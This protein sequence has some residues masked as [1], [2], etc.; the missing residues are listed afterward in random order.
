VTQPTGNQPAGESPRKC[1]AEIPTR[2]IRAR[3]DAAQSGTDNATHWAAADSYDA[4]SANSPAVR[5]TL[6][7]RSRYERENNGY[8]KGT[9]RTH[10]NYTIHGGPTLRMQTGSDGFNAMVEA[11][12]RRWTKACKFRRKLRVMHMAKVGDGESLAWTFFNPGLADAVQLDF[13]PLECDQCSTPYLPA[14]E[15]SRIDGVHFDRYGNVTA[16]DI[17]PEHPGGQW[18]GYNRDP[19]E[20]PARF[21]LHWFMLER[22]GQ[23]RGIPDTTATLSL[24]AAARRFREATVGA[25]ESAADFGVIF[26][27]NMQVNDGPDE[28]RPLTEI[29][30]DKRMAI[31]APMGWDGHQMKGEHPSTTFDMF[32]K[33]TVN[34][35]AR[36]LSMPRNL[37]MCD[38]SDYNFSSGQL[39]HHTYFAAC[40]NER[41]DGDDLV[42]DPLFGLW[43][44]E[45]RDVYGWAVDPYPI[46]P[47]AWDWPGYPKI[48]P[49]KTAKARAASL[50]VGATSL[51]RIYREDGLDFEDELKVMAKDYGVEVD[52]MRAILRNAVF[53]QAAAPEPEEEEEEEEPRM[54]VPAE[55]MLRGRNGYART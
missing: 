42:V 44:P 30:F 51:T 19:I 6:R 25:A 29:E 33:A 12:W 34:E 4:D 38:S 35:Q 21:I 9:I 7:E 47:H 50:G 20:V 27:T 48:D 3:Y 53:R 46:P 14:G 2:P 26:N 32:N 5:K 1:L 23:H 39:D 15:K 11:A 28:I 49:T 22:A 37:A 16:F 36:P 10:A 31:A 8:S 45:A 40:D 55:A 43:F 24:S 52:E 41:L 13:R 18:S 17:L 54:A